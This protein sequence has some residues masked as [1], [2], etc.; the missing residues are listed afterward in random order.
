MKK[1]KPTSL[2]LE[3]AV[4]LLI[5][6]DYIPP[7]F[8]LL[9][10]TEAFLEEAEVE[11]HNAKIDCL[12]QSQLDFL[13][14]RLNVCE[15]RHK[16]AQDLIDLLHYE[17]DNR[18]V[19]SAIELSNEAT[20]V[21][22]VKFNSVFDWS[23]SFGIGI[24]EWNRSH[25]SINTKK[26]CQETQ[27]R[28]EDVTI[29]IYKHNKISCKIGEKSYK[30]SSFEKIG[31]IDKRKNSPNYLGVLLIGL[32]SKDMKF[33]PNRKPDP[34][35]KTAICKLRR[36]LMTLTNIA[37]DPF[38]SFNEGDGWKP[39]FKLLDD[40]KNAETR[41]KTSASHMSF[42]ENENCVQDFERENDETQKWLDNY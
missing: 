12:P 7:D 31:L 30:R 17:I 28:W 5:N 39:R 33:P 41:A 16:L 2:T 1:V 27:A 32:S 9:Q 18:L 34:K 38:Y 6:L 20:A 24:T 10:M 4:A 37:D 8:S 26:V 29:K 42:N 25:S 35:H 40:R 21:P 14:L 11:Y 19:D 3:E 23:T 13:K 22:R 36:I 15:T